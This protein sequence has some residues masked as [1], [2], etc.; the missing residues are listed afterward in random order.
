[1]QSK[2]TNSP[3][4]SAYHFVLKLHQT[5][6]KT[7]N[8]HIPATTIRRTTC[9]ALKRRRPRNKYLSRKIRPR[10]LPWKLIAFTIDCRMHAGIETMH[11]VDAAPMSPR[12]GCTETP[13]RR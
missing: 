2:A 9:V 3:R 10:T 4:L 5:N 12:L 6:A 11:I 7:I 13:G 1:M 8:H